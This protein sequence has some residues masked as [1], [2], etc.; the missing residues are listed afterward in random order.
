MDEVM[1]S[2]F[3]LLVS[4]PDDQVVELQDD[5]VGGTDAAVEACSSADEEE[6]EVA[7][8]A[9]SYLPAQAAPRL[10]LHVSSGRS[11]QQQ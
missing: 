9:F 11:F 7:L 5:S 3:W 4:E 2:D 6:L 10:A 1:E 8:G